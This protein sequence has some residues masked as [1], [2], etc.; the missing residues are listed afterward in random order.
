[1]C[2]GVDAGCCV[3]VVVDV[4]VYGVGID[5]GVQVAYDNIRVHV[6]AVKHKF[7]TAP[8]RAQPCTR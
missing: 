1:M 4:R 8:V 7:T 6:A 2:V 5:N 3:D